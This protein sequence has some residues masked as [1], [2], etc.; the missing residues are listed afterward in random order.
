MNGVGDEW[1][2]SE[3]KLDAKWNTIFARGCKAA[4]FNVLSAT[5][6]GWHEVTQIRWMA[7]QNGRTRAGVM[8]S[9]T[10][11]PLD[12]APLHSIP[13][14]PPPSPFALFHA[15]SRSFFL[16][17][18][19]FLS[20]PFPSNVFSS[21]SSLR[22]YV[23]SRDNFGWQKTKRGRMAVTRETRSMRHFT[24]KVARFSMEMLVLTYS[25][26]E[27]DV[28]RIIGLSIISKENFLQT[29]R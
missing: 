12:I 27:R 5:K 7:F 24:V 4:G 26:G 16:S 28:F 29:S 1:K 9:R 17:R 19:P 8:P 15:F 21:H 6:Y 11:R 10:D 18:F 13:P 2:S 22:K 20:S 14:P 3:R 23:W 25:R